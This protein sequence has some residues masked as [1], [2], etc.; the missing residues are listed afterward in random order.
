M[1]PYFVDFRTS[2]F[3]CR[4]EMWQFCT[5]KQ[6]ETQKK[7]DHPK[8]VCRKDSNFVKRPGADSRPEP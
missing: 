8:M 6:R 3:I 1:I 4:V 2:R 5:R 7:A